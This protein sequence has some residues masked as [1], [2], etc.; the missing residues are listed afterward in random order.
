MGDRG[1]TATYAAEAARGIDYTRWEIGGEPQ[2]MV[3]H[4]PAR[5]YYTRWEIGGEPQQD[6]SAPFW[7]DDYTRWEIG[8]EPQLVEAEV[9]T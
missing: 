8:G 6:A 1:G 3:A 7:Y 5:S 4:L 9:N 2:L